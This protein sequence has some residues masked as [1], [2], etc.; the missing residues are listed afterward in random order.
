MPNTPVLG[1]PYP[2][3]AD[4]A[5][6][7][8]D[9]KALADSLDA[10][11][12]FLPVGAVFL[13]ALAAVPGGALPNGKAAF[14]FCLGQQVSAADYPKL[15]ALFGAPGGNVTVP[16][17]SGRVPVGKGPPPFDA[18][19][20]VGGAMTHKLVAN[21]MP[22][23]I[24]PHNIATNQL[25]AFQTTVESAD[26]SH[27]VD[28]TL[29]NAGTGAQI[30]GGVAQAGA[31]TATVNTRGRSVSHNHTV[32][33][34]NHTMTGGVQSAGGDGSHN[35]LQPYLTMNYVLRAG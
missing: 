2:T 8:R 31:G 13:W 17:L 30:V 33:A 10:L 23:H 9:I 29:F 15:A 24:H 6:V 12:S 4:T 7:P 25:A 16:D 3:S 5:D 22:A 20:N 11:P 18:V 19:G 28:Y 21:E 34:H 1:L 32:G 26:H 35:N 27:Q 14:L